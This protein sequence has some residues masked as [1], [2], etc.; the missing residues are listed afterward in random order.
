MWNLLFFFWS[1]SYFSNNGNTIP[2]C[3][4]LLCEVYGVQTKYSSISVS[5]LSRGVGEQEK[6]WSSTAL[7]VYM[8]WTMLSLTPSEAA[9]EVMLYN[10]PQA[11]IKPQKRRLHLNNMTFILALCMHNAIDGGKKSSILWKNVHEWLYVTERKCDRENK[12]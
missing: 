1:I 5:Q 3:I 7:A 10:R 6:D 2:N 12:K 9:S 8:K 4:S 11:S